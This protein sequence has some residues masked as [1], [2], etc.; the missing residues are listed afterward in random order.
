MRIV[1]RGNSV[2]PNVVGM[3]KEPAGV[4]R[5]VD[6]S[7]NVEYVLMRAEVYGRLLASIAADR[8]RR[9]RVFVQPVEIASTRNPALRAAAF[10]CR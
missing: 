7:S 3:E 4:T 8:S 1:L 9:F 5:A 10:R 2:A 6:P